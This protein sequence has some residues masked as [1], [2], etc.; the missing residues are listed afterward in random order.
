M[1]HE[2]V[3]YYDPDDLLNEMEDVFVPYHIR[4]CTLAIVSIFEAFLSSAIDRL[5]GKGKIPQVKDSYKQRLKWAFLVILNSNF[6]NDTMQA[7]LP[8]LCLDLD[9]AR[10]VRNLWM[11]N[12]G[13]FTHRYKNDTLDVLGHTPIVVEAFKGFH[14]SPKTKVPFPIDAGFFE[15]I[16]RSHIEALHHLHHMMQVVH[17]GQ[18]RS[19]GYKAAKK[20][21]DWGRILAGV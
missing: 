5:V 17:F 1:F 19:Y 20:N 3:R 18:I 8:Q 21:I 12:N 10:R 2:W 9:H 11:H 13:N 14:R 4:T 15:Q 16:S 7:R 6:G